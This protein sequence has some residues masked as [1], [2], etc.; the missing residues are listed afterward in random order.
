MVAIVSGNG[1]GLYNSSSNPLGTGTGGQPGLGHLGD[2]LYVNSSTGNLIIQQQ[3]EVLASIGLDLNLVRTYNSQG[4]VDGDNNDNWRIGLVRSLYSLTGTVNTA[5]STVTK[6]YGDGHES[7]FTYDSTRSLYVSTDGD[8]A[9]DTLSYNGTTWIFTDGTAGAKEE[10][11]SDGAGGWRLWHTID[12][13][14]NTTTFNYNPT[15]KLLDNVV[16]ANGQ[17]TTFTW[18]GNDLTQIAVT[19][20]NVATSST[21]YF[22][23]TSHRLT[24]VVADLNLADGFVLQDTR[25]NTTGAAGA[26][27]LYDSVNGATYVTSYTYDG[28]SKRIASV[29]SGDGT[30]V[31]FLY[32]AQNRIAS[33]KDGAGQITTYSYAS[34]TGN[35]TAPRVA[36]VTTPTVGWV[37]NSASTLE[38]LSGTASNAQVAFDSNGNGMAVWVS[39]S[40]V[41]YATYD[42]RTKLWTSTTSM[43]LDGSLAG[44]PS[45]PH[46][47]MSANGNALVTWIQGTNVYARRYLVSTATWDGSALTPLENVANAVVSGRYSNKFSWL[48]EAP[49][50]SSVSVFIS[51]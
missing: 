43:L 31:S 16:D 28:S 39:G 9:H 14:S 24:Q 30:T 41:M 3:D 42:V 49:S 11:Q 37:S 23:D 8:G 50:L 40:D 13:D 15:S 45:T 34:V 5:G 19:A 35:V 1:L 21:R 47:S 27:G 20:N 6:V 33:V 7:V 4:T 2:Q 22:Y 44:T 36:T 17:T 29:T 10:Y 48:T 12:A 38:A 18:S 46:L 26:D 51:S 32:D 25:N